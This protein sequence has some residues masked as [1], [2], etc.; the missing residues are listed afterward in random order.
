MYNVK[1]EVHTALTVRTV[2][3]R[4]TALRILTLIYRDIETCCLQIQILWKQ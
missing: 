2:V 1:F 3:C 4:N